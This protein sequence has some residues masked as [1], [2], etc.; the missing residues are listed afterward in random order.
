MIWTK[1]MNI[2]L[3]LFI[4]HRETDELKLL[5]CLFLEVQFDSCHVW[6]MWPGFNVILGARVSAKNRGDDT[7]LHNAA[8]CGQLSVIKSL[9]KNKAQVNAQNEHGN[10]PLHYACF[11][12]HAE[13]SQYLGMTNNVWVHA[14]CPLKTFNFSAKWSPCISVQ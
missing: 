1:E 11:N 12:N 13:V 8:Q 9:V 7:P 3:L 14:R 6:V 4:G 10:S 2:G 5:N